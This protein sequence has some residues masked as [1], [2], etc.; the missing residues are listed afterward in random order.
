MK[1]NKIKYK[2]AVDQF[3]LSAYQKRNA[4]KDGYG[5]NVRGN[6]AHALGCLK[7][8]QAYQNVIYVKDMDYKYIDGFIGTLIGTMSNSTINKY[9]VHFRRFFGFCVNW[10]MIYVNHANKLNKLKESR[11]VPYSF[12]DEEVE[13]ILAHAGKYQNFFEFM[14]E[15]GL[16]PTDTWKLTQDNFSTD[17][18]GMS[19]KVL[20]KK[21]NK[22]ITVPISKS[23]Q[24]I[25]ETSGHRL[26]PWA[27]KSSCRRDPILFL[28]RSFGRG[29]AGTYYCN[30]YGI[31][32]HTFRHTYAM[33]LLAKGVSKDIVQQLLGHSSVRVTE[34]YAREIPQPNLR[35]ALL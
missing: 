30:K 11:A 15:T 10:E 3:M 5:P 20:T 7:K 17:E 28:K 14:L 19:M 32:L 8:L 25:V 2:K 9:I 31:T 27:T 35:E 16:R 1:T 4:W 24:Q 33:R 21:G 12:S 18:S 6:D 26:F 13:R 22:T 23:A 34:L 29:G